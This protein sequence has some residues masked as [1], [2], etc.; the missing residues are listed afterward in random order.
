[1]R[2]TCKRRCSPYGNLAVVQSALVRNLLR[3][4]SAST[5]NVW[6][7][8]TAREAIWFLLVSALLVLVAVRDA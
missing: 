4:V 6:S 8:V 7:T 3:R 5:A 2:H 1:M